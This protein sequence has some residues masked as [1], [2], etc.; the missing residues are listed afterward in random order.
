[1]RKPCDY[2]RRACQRVC[3]EHMRS[4]LLN[5]RSARG[6]HA[7]PFYRRR[8]RIAL[9]A[10]KYFGYHIVAS[11]YK[12]A[13]TYPYVLS[14]YIVIIVQRRPRYPRARKLHRFKVRKRRKLTRPANL[15]CDV[16]NGRRRFLG[17]KLI[18][19]R[20]S[21]KSLRIPQR[22]MRPDIIELYHHSVYK[23]IKLAAYLRYALDCVH[24]LVGVVKYAYERAYRKTV[25][26]Q[27]FYHFRLL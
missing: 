20:P 14:Q 25:L 12:H 24:K 5:M 22:L 16:V 23:E 26:A 27:K 11:P 19:Y 18:C 7:R 15:P 2:L 9:H 1:M 21:R 3:A 13:R 4:A 10:R 8:W 6:T 17:R